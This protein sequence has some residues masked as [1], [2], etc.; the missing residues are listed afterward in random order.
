MRNARSS[1]TVLAPE[2][3]HNGYMDFLDNLIE[4]S[5]SKRPQID[6]IRCIEFTS[7]ELTQI[8]DYLIKTKFPSADIYIPFIDKAVF[9]LSKELQIICASLRYPHIKAIAETYKSSLYLSSEY[10]Q[11]DILELATAL[12]KLG[13]IIKSDGT[14]ANF[15]DIAEAFGVMF[16]ID[17]TNINQK[18]WVAMNRKIRLT[19]FI[20][21]LR[22]ALLNKSLGDPNK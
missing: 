22:E 20:D 16:N 18:R 12:H 14:K 9:I 5:S 15:Q 17:F 19:K 3:L 11:T 13:V 7:A 21:S 2:E 8:K 6:I 1:R 10:T 4:L